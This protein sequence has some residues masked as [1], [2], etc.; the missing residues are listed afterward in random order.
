VLP[1]AL[2]ITARRHRRVN[3][4]QPTAFMI[5]V[6]SIALAFVALTLALVPCS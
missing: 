6:I 2:S 4:V 3:I 1:V 5:R